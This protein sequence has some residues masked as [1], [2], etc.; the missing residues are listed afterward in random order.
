[1]PA[2]CRV[3]AGV[4]GLVLL[5][6][7]AAVAWA[8]QQ[9]KVPLSFLGAVAAGLQGWCVALGAP[10]SVHLGASV[11]VGGTWTHAG[12]FDGTAQLG[13]CAAALLAALPLA[14][15]GVWLARALDA[16]GE[17]EHLVAGLLVAP[18]FAALSMALVLALP[19]A[20]EGVPA[21]DVRISG[22]LACAPLPMGCVVL[23][24]ALLTCPVGGLVRYAW[25]ARGVPA[26]DAA[27]PRLVPLFASLL[28]FGLL[29][30][31][32]AV[33]ASEV[34]AL[35]AS[36][37]VPRDSVL[38]SH[39]LPAQR[40]AVGLAAFASVA[41]ADVC[42][43]LTLLSPSAPAVDVRARVPW[44]ER[45]RIQVDGTIVE[46]SAP[47]R[48]LDGSLALVFLGSTFAMGVLLRVLKRDGFG[49]CAWACGLFLGFV[50]AAIAASGG[51]VSGALET[52]T[53]GPAVEIWGVC[54]SALNAKLVLL[55][56]VP[57]VGIGLGTGRSRGGRAW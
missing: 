13:V 3:S 20:P 33:V 10:L 38:A 23:A 16:A 50:S 47:Y 15:A 9:C 35:P 28:G 42:E 29:A 17:R 45:T 40:A 49:D 30:V 51:W 18:A 26:W 44:G 57:M 12:A 31:G 36:P 48:T 5:V 27:M 24:W 32:S 46:A 14:L 34:W 52:V 8:A 25:R 56:I 54:G 19:F 55:V 39:V 22:R 41:G 37:P 2:A 53:G 7:G 21:G 4:L 43:R 6:G 1:M 11:D